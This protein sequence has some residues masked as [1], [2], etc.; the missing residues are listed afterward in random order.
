MT[1]APGPDL[2]V[3]HIV[4]VVSPSPL[5]TFFPEFTLPNHVTI[6]DLLSQLGLGVRHNT[7]PPLEQFSEIA[8]ETVRSKGN[9]PLLKRRTV[10]KRKHTGT[11]LHS[12]V[13]T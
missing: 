4:R 6:S 12:S 2:G 5:F 3:C 10:R 11:C 9:R 13:I 1:I 7:S 8:V